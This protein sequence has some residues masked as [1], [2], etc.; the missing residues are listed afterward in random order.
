MRQTVLLLLCPALA[1]CE[2]LG[3]LAEDLGDVF[4]FDG[5]AQV[6]PPNDSDAVPL[7]SPVVIFADDTY[8]A[9]DFAADAVDAEGAITDLTAAL[10]V[11]QRTSGADN[12]IYV[13]TTAE[14]WPASSTITVRT[15]GEIDRQV[16][17]STVADAGLFD[18]PPDLGFE[19]AEPP[20]LPVGWRGFGDVGAIRA[21]GSLR[22]SAG[23]QLLALS[24]G[25]AVRRAAV[26][27][28][29]SMVVSDPID[30][31]PSQSLAFDYQFQSSEFN[32]YCGS[33]FD[34]TLM[35]VASGPDGMVARVVE[36][37]NIVCREDRQV[38][39]DFPGLPDDGDETYK[40]TEPTAV[41]VDLAAV[42]SPF[43]VSFLVTDV[44]DTILTSVV[45]VDGITLP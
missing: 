7:R 20:D 15:T 12:D 29:S 18:T 31:G 44:G 27:D 40:G 34:D 2:D 23:D 25:D 26:S 37:V 45:G 17:F 13:L 16:R 38:R 43:S 32:D 4:D 6:V 11:E 22:P 35:M 10:R 41:E 1:G 3:K 42:G 21:R 30:L 8:A 28:S 24:T 19:T 33:R 5:I 9:V 36:S 14:G 39:A